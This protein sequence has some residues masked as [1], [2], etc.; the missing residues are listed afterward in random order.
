MAVI[1]QVY[2]QARFVE[3]VAWAA[4]WYS[5]LMMLE[6]LTALFGLGENELLRKLK[7]TSRKKAQVTGATSEKNDDDD[8]G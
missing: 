7:I 8:K 6:I 4:L 5:L 3:I 2:L 1:Q